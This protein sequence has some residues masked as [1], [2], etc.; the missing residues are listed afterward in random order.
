MQGLYVACGG[1]TW[2]AISLRVMFFKQKDW[3]GDILQR[4]DEPE[5]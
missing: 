5:Q 4:A 1:E 2:R 3:I